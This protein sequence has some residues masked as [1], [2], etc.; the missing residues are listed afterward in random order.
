MII[1]YKRKNDESDV[2]KPSRHRLNQLFKVNNITDSGMRGT[3]FVS[4]YDATR[5]AWHRCSGMP[6]KNDITA[7]MKKQTQI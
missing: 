7:V 6:A 1:D 4:R 2:E 3:A 5:R